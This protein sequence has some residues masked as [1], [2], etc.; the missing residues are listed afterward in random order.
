MYSH[1]VSK[2][3]PFVL[4]AHLLNENTVLRQCNTLGMIGNVCV[5]VVVMVVEEEGGYLC[6]R[7]VRSLPDEQVGDTYRSRQALARVT[8]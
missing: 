3:C 7:T 5:V 4:P 1:I 8:R 2:T 6:P